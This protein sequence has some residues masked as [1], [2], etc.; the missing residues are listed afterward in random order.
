M[1]TAVACWLLPRDTNG[2]MLSVP[3]E[4]NTCQKE[5]YIILL[6]LAVLQWVRT[7][8]GIAEKKTAAN[9]NSGVLIQAQISIFYKV[10]V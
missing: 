6:K 3:S 4:T 2:M 8:L 10:K 5:E 7:P 9:T 1:N